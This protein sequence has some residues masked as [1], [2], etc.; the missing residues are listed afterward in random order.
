LTEPDDDK[1]NE[2]PGQGRIC[3]TRLLSW[4]DQSLPYGIID[5]AKS[6][7]KLRLAM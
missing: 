3:E 2:L 1:S 6:L 7:K 5:L 4:W